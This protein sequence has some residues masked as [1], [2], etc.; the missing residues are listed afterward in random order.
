M[1]SV[2]ITDLRDLFKTVKHALRH[3]GILG[4]TDEGW[5]IVNDAGMVA[6]VKSVATDE[7]GYLGNMLSCKVST[8][9]WSMSWNVEM[10]FNTSSGPI[11]MHRAYSLA[12]LEE[13]RKF[14]YQLP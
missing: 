7:F 13:K 11:T 2:P 12:Y 1:V 5:P 8:K 4:F 9:A 14:K 10:E 3:D 6:I